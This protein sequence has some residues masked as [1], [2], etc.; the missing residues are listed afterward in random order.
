MLK[1]STFREIRSSL[2]RYIAILAIVAL[3]VGFFSGLKVTQEAMVKTTDK[4]LD[5]HNMFDYKL[6]ST[7]GFEDQDIKTLKSLDDAEAVEGSNSQDMLYH[8]DK[9]SEDRVLSIH[10][11]TKSV[12]TLGLMDGRMPKAKNECVI[13]HNLGKEMIGK[14]IIL[15]S[16]NDKDS[17][18]KFKYK[19]LKVVGTVVSPTYLNFERGTT[20]L[21]NGNVNGFAYVNSGSFDVD[22]YSEVYIALKEKYPIYS[23][24]YKDYIDETEDRIDAALTAAGKPRHD[25]IV[26]KAMDEWK[27]GKK[28]YDDGL[29]EYE[30]KRADSFAKLADAR[31]ELDN[32]WNQIENGQANLDCKEKELNEAIP[33][34]KT[35]IAQVEEGIKAAQAYGQPTTELEAKKAALQSKLTAANGGL[36]EIKKSRNTLNSKKAELNSGEAEYKANYAKAVKEFNDAK[37]DLDDAKAELDKS[38]KEIKDIKKADTYLLDRNTNVGYACFESDSQIVDGIAK[39]F[40]LFFFLVAALVCMTTMTRM[41]DEQRTQIGVLKALGY[42]NPAVMGKYLFYSGSASLIG[43]II[44]FFAGSYIF[45][46]VIWK[47]YGMMYDFSANILYVINWKLGFATTAAALVCA[48][49]STLFSIIG[50]IRETPAQMIRPK[51]PKSGKRILLERIPF[52][53]NRL[54]FLKKVSLRNVFR[55][56]KRFLMMIL[57]ISGCTALLVAGFGIRD[58][59]QNIVNYQF[60]EIQTFQYSITFDKN[61]TEDRQKTFEKSTSDEYK[62]ILYLGQSSADVLIG[63]N[64]KSI[65][66]LAINPD[67]Y[68]RAGEYVDLHTKAGDHVDFPE[69]GEAVICSK[70][71]RMY[72]LKVGDEITLRDSSMHKMKVKISGICENFIYNYIYISTDTYEKGFGSAPNMKTAYVLCDGD[73]DDAKASATAILDNDRVAAVSVNDEMRDRVNNMMKS[74]NYVVILVIVSAGALAFIVLYNLTNI[75]ITERVREIATI[76]VLGFRPRE[77]SAYVFRENIILTAVSAIV[78][79]IMG[80]AL[81]EFIIRQINVDMI[82]FDVRVTVISYCL[83]VIFTFVF[84]FIVNL[85]MHRKLENISMTESLKSIE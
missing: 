78:G 35:G 55:Y 5:A 26:K 60:D 29:A 63:N 69:T 31:S 45:P 53:W 13:D 79:L 41:V 49:G 72:K 54:G 52:I 62:N 43:S 57:G 28:E 56:K 21:G 44:G 71:S 23:D 11:I 76:K 73:G 83:S 30:S 84:A 36:S 46:L 38:L 59:I 8:T 24:A 34:L 17:L 37:A 18:K 33:Q 20:T 85:V 58:S 82:S 61:M 2:G 77:T 16:K 42:S 39:V 6:V 32:G 80:R 3:G 12:N 64:T 66:L 48:M 22:Y 51:A 75:N 4:Y 27:D 1:K 67:D 9:D 19:K 50:E 68:D 70:L 25:R 7:L 15:S 14:Y 10:T 47:C 40:P 81:L 65:S 74:L